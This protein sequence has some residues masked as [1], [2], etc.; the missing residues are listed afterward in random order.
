[1]I[2][3]FVHRCHPRLGS[4][5]GFPAFAGRKLGTTR[6]VPAFAGMTHF[7]AISHEILLEYQQLSVYAHKTL[8][9]PTSP[10]TK[11]P[12]PDFLADYITL[13]A[14]AQH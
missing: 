3:D 11:A 9:Q 13:H 6:E 14:R 4:M 8:T 5:K 1:M 2:P 10:H 7:V 12:L